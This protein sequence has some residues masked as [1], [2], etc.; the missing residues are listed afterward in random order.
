VIITNLI[1]MRL[2]GKYFGIIGAIWAV[3]SV[4]GLLSEVL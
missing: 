3:G 4:T 1:P 2:R